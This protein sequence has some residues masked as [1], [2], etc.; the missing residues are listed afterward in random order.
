[1]EQ[2]Y[3]ILIFVGVSISI[4]IDVRY[5]YQIANVSYMYTIVNVQYN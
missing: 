2:I 4:P 1:M 3:S 5:T